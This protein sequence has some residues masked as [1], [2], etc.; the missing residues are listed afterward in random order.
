MAKCTAFDLSGNVD[1]RGRDGKVLK[2]TCEKVKMAVLND[3][4]L[5]GGV[6]KYLIYEV[7]GNRKMVRESV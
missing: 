4:I 6:N 1:V 7:R 2:D 5:C 3:R